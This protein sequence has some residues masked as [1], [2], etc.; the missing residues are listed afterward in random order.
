MMP[1]NG[2]AAVRPLIPPGKK[3]APPAVKLPGWNLN[4]ST[5]MARTGTATFHHVITLLTRAKMRMA[6]KLTATKTAIRMMV[7][8]RPA[9]VILSVW[10]LKRPG[11]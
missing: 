9:P 10:V 5:M 3:P 6:R 2:S 7:T 4:A 1:D 11:Q 8:T